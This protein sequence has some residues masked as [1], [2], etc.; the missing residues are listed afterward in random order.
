VLEIWFLNM[1]YE[2]QQREWRYT[3][4]DGEL[5]P[6]WGY[7]SFQVD[8]YIKNLGQTPV[9]PPW[10]PTRWIITDGEREY[11]SDLMWQW[12]SRRTG[13]YKQPVIEPGQSAGWT[14]LAFPIDRHQ[15]VKA[16]EFEWNGQLYRQ[17]FDLGPFGNAHNYKDCG[18]PAPHTFRPT[19]TPRH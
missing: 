6:L 18:D 11:I 4:E 7:R 16:V 12:V 19:P 1:H 13:F 10:Q 14:F 17:E 9:E 8:M 2:C 3:G 5:H 15:W